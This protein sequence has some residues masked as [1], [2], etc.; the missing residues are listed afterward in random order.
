MNWDEIEGKWMQ[1][2]GSAR[3]KWGKLSDQELEEA[4]GNRE[5]L[6]GLIQENYGKTREEAEEAIDSWLKSI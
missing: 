2:K 5:Q 3:E 1:F 6:L 4:K